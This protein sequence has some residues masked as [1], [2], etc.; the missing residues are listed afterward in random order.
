MVEVE[1]YRNENPVHYNPQEEATDE[2]AA[3]PAPEITANGPALLDVQD[4]TRPLLADP[5]E[6]GIRRVGLIYSPRKSWWTGLVFVL[7]SVTI[8]VITIVTAFI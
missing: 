8:L 7:L 2:E 6:M 1:N 4:I 3:S 5:Q